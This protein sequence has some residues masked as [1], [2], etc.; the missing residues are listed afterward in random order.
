MNLL[1][2]YFVFPFSKMGECWK[3]SKCN[4]HSILR[5]EKKEVDDLSSSM[6]HIVINTC[7]DTSRGTAEVQPLDY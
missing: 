3:K 2:F 5:K 1:F 7:N 4:Y 6:Y